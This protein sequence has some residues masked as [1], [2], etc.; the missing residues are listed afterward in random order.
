MSHHTQSLL[1][2]AQQADLPEQKKLLAEL[3]SQTPV[4]Q[5]LINALSTSKAPLPDLWI[6]AGAITQSIWNTFHGLPT[7]S[8]LKDIDLMY[9]DPD[10]SWE[11]E[12]T[13][14]QHIQ[15]RMDHLPWPLD[16]KNVGRIH[17]W[18]H[19]RFG[20]EPL[21]PFKNIAEAVQT[22]PFTAS[23]V[24]LQIYPYAPPQNQAWIAPFGF[25]DLLALRLRPNR[26]LAK[27]EIYEQK[28]ERW[29]KQWPQ[30]TLLKDSQLS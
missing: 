22:W 16:I 30:L 17:K 23:A 1:K 29:L 26:T 5:M 12:D 9:F 18:Y 6:G 2:K 20:G 13:H 27:A 21:A 7:E 3:M 28:A 25:D 15:K 8:F 10:A 4:Y 19:Q 11:A 24:A 14:I